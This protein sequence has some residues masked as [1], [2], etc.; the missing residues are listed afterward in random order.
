VTSLNANADGSVTNGYAGWHPVAATPSHPSHTA[1]HSTTIA[2][3]AEILRSYFGDDKVKPNGSPVTLGSLPWLVGMNSGTGNV[4][5]RS[6]S[7]FTQLQLENGASRLYLGVHYGYDNLQG[8][9]L[10]LGVAD[11]ILLGSHEPAARGISPRI[12]SVSL[13]S[14]PAT[15]LKRTDLYGFF[16]KDTT[17]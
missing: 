16:G 3:A 1:G 12:S 6:V 2:A 15:L 14:V 7:T 4:T 11:T 10:G 5:S 9:L 13:L 8:Q 17:K